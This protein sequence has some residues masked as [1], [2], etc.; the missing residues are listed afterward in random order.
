MQQLQLLLDNIEKVIIGKTEAIRLAITGLLAGGHLLIEDIPGTGKTTLALAIARSI[1]ASFARIQFTADLLPTDI[2][3]VSIY[4][5]ELGKFE[6]LKGPIFNHIV[7]ADEINRGTPRVQSGLLEAMNEQQVSID[8]TTYPLSEPFFV[9]ATQNPLT[10]SGT[11]PLLAAQLD[12]FLIKIHLGYLS[13]QEEIAMVRRQQK[14]HP[15]TSLQPVM[16]V[17]E[18]VQYQ[19]QVKQVTVDDAIYNYIAALV[20]ATRSSSQIQYGVSHRGTL[21]LFNSVRAYAL[22]CGRDYV[23]PDDVKTLV[24][25]ALE[26]R[27]IEHSAHSQQGFARSFLDKLLATV[28]VPI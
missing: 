8:G 27:L 6:F 11:Y 24:V 7:L 9:I 23:L 26:H 17:A 12:R 19:Q 5:Q 25:P 22:V 10:F 13:L 3:G 21:A 15:L 20:Q 14:I 28:P 16:S 2:T 18:I 4:N 1:E